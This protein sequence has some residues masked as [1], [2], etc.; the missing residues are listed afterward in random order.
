MTI[1]QMVRD[2]IAPLVD[3]DTRKWLDRATRAI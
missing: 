1:R 2:T 3:E